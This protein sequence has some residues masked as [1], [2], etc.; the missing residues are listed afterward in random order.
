MSRKGPLFN[1]YVAVLFATLSI[2]T[3]AIWVRLSSA[4]AAVIAFYRLFFTILLM[5]PFLYQHVK[6]FRAIKLKNLLWCAFA[7]VSLAFH[8]ILWF[9]SLEYTSVASSVVLVTLQPLFA[10]AGSLL[11]FKEK[12]HFG[13]LVGAGSAIFGSFLISWGD[14][15]VSRA[16]LFGDLLALAACLMITVYLMVGQSVRRDMNLF[17]YTYL[18]YAFAT[19]TLFIYV[20]CSREPF[21]PYPAQDWIMFMLLAVFPTLLGHSIF[22]WSVKWV[23][24]NTLSMSILGEPVGAAILAY[25]LFHEALHPMQIIGSLIILSGIFIY[26]RL[27]SRQ[28]AKQRLSY[29]ENA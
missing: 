1:P 11:L 25:F 28:K 7:G 26:L 3:S 27:E 23:G 13:A 17:T 19:V 4:P 22:N 2:S 24:V 10:F 8:F 15:G 12:L 16:A 6:A 9:V 29:S 14:F 21:V 5:T 20:L 18:V